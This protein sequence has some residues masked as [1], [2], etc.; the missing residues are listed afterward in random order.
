[1]LKINRFSLRNSLKSNHATEI[2]F[3]RIGYKPSNLTDMS[4]D[5]GNGLVPSQGRNMCFEKRRIAN[6]LL[7]SAS[8]ARERVCVHCTVP[9]S[10]IFA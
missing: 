5:T 7:H 9:T 2:C 10:V 4:V 8:V 1:M 3:T 6:A